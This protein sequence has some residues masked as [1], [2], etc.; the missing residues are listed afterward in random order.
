M[1]I[2]VYNFIVYKTSYV[3]IFLITI[4]KTD[5]Y[6]QLCWTRVASVFLLLH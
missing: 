1:E 6:M 4:A 3:H 2:V 5:A